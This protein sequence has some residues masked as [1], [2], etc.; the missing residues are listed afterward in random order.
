LLAGGFQ[1]MVATDA[2]A[3]HLYAPEGGSRTVLKLKDQKFVVSDLGP[4][5]EDEVLFWHRI[6][7]IL[8]GRPTRRL[9]RRPKQRWLRYDLAGRPIRGVK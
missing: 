7:E 4:I 2:L 9:K 3:W 5:H 8:P 1:M 6:K